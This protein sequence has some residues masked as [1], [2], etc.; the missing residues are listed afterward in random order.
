MGFFSRLTCLG[1]FTII[2]LIAAAICAVLYFT[3][4]LEFGS[5]EKSVDMPELPSIS[6]LTKKGKYDA[7]I[8]I[9]DQPGFAP[10]VWGNGGLESKKGSYFQKNY[11]LKLKLVVMNETESARTALKNGEADIEY[12]NIDALPVEL[13]KDASLSDTKY[14]MLLNFSTG[15]DVIVANGTINSTADLKGKRVAF[16]EGTSSQTLLINAL[17]TAGLTMSDIIAEKVTSIVD[18]A[19]AFKSKQVDCAIVTTPQEEGCILQVKGA[20]KLTTTAQSSTLI[21]E[22]LIAKKKWIDENRETA[23]K[24]AEAIIAANSELT[25]NP[26]A[27]QE[28]GNIF[29]K[30]LEMSTS[31]LVAQ[32]AKFKYATLADQMAWMGLSGSYNGLTAEK[33]YSKMSRL[34]SSLGIGKSAT[35][36]AKISLT[37]LVEKASENKALT[38]EQKAN[39]TAE[40]AFTT[41][42]E[43]DKTAQAFAV[44]E[45]VIG[46]GVGKSALDNEAYATIDREFGDII[47]YYPKARIRIEASANGTGNESLAKQRAQAVSN[48]L[49]TEYHVNRNRIVTASNNKKVQGGA[50]SVSDKCGITMCLI[51]GE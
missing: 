5:T 25:F 23:E 27:L 22:G 33:V 29:E 41:P 40:N 38:N 48:Y 34:Y 46:F 16:M 44:K 11:G 37:D 26:T 1:R 45:T 20:H 39:G 21:A 31:I 47:L 15:A 13:S 2:G 17:E 28:A 12:C 9:K 49:T 14:F 3:G 4:I 51:A 50:S 42:T 6:S 35:T 18:A 10:I 30:E 19:Q 24:L 7:T 32:S 8:V 36:W 43:K